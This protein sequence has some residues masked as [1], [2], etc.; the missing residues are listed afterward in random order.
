M[1]KT[2]RDVAVI[3][4]CHTVGR[5]PRAYPQNKN[6]TIGA[7]HFR[8]FQILSL[9]FSTQTDF[10]VKTASECKNSGKWQ[11]RQRS[12]GAEWSGFDF[13]GVHSLDVN[14]EI[15]FIRLHIDAS[16]FEECQPNISTCHGFRARYEALTLLH[17]DHFTVHFFK[18]LI[19]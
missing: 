1:L 16:A 18:R 5:T 8:A 10:T 4:G 12:S 2:I 14:Y 15:K 9:R 7:E 13:L 11:E 3:Y 6:W 19:Q 17:G